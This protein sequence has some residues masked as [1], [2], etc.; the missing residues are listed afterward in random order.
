MANNALVTTK[1]E[2]VRIALRSAVEGAFN[3]L[4]QPVTTLRSGRLSA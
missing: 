3:P 2:T 1:N 4:R